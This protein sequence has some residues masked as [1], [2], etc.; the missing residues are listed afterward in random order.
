MKPWAVGASGKDAGIADGRCE[1]SRHDAQ[2]DPKH[3]TKH[4]AKASI[5]LRLLKFR[6]SHVGVLHFLLQRLVLRLK[7]LGTTSK[8]VYAW[9]HILDIST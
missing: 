3:W 5:V 1:K 6:Q 2:H 8:I 4:A 7:D 9:N